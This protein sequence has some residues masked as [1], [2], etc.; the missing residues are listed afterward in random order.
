MCPE[1]CFYTIYSQNLKN[2]KKGTKSITRER[3]DLY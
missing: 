3:L 2:G 1:K